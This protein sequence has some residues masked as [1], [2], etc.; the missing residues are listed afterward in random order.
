MVLAR[1]M[2]IVRMNRPIGP[3]CRAKTL[4]D[5]RADR[6]FA[7]IGPGRA[8]RHRFA[9]RLLA[10][11]LRAQEVAGEEFLVGPRAIGG[12]GPDIAGGVVAI[13]LIRRWT[14]TDAA[15]HDGALLPELIRQV[16]GG[17]QLLDPG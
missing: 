12:I 8:A 9:L 16:F 17:F 6:R 11:D 15:R 10:V 7:G 2:P 1:T 13:D 14:V 5:R 3:F 4:L